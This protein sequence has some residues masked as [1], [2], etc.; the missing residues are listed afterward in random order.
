MWTRRKFE[1]SSKNIKKHS[2]DLNHVHFGHIYTYF[3]AESHEFYFSFIHNHEWHFN[4]FLSMKIPK[5]KSAMPPEPKPAEKTKPEESSIIATKP[6]QPVSKENGVSFST[7][8]V[9]SRK[10]WIW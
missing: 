8:E 7:E 9:Q 1:Y 2:I 3:E 6:D 10:A 5:K 4:E